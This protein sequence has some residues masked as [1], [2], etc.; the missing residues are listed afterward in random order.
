MEDCASSEGRSLS[1]RYA[2][3][4]PIANDGPSTGAATLRWL[5][6]PFFSAHRFILGRPVSAILQ[7]FSVFVLIGVVWLLVNAVLISDIVRQ[8]KQA[9]RDLI[10]KA[11]NRISATSL[12]YNAAGEML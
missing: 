5:L 11:L 2:H 3:R 6:L 7:I 1:P 10:L 4:E 9:M 8:T 12:P